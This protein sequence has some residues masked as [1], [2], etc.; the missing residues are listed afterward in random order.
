MADNNSEKFSNVEN[1]RVPH[2]LRVE[3]TS[4]DDAMVVRQIGATILGLRLNGIDVLT[5]GTDLTP[6]EPDERIKIDATHTMLPAGPN[7]QGPIQGPQHGPSRYLEYGVDQ[8]DEASAFFRAHV[9]M[10]DLDHSTAFRVG[11][12]TAEI[13]DTAANVTDAET[14]LSIGKHLYLKVAE[15]DLPN[16]RFVET[17]G[18]DTRLAGHKQSGKAGEPF[19]GDFT[20]IVDHISQ[21]KTVFHERFTGSQLIEI[22]GIGRL[23]LSANALGPDGQAVPVM[24][25]LWHR[26]GSDT[27]CFE[28]VAGFRVDESGFYNTEIPVSPGGSIQLKT[29]L[30]LVA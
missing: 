30:E 2:G 12:G 8:P 23:R 28:P 14:G 9:P 17:D 22:T 19:E 24:L 13:V 6:D 10:W 5:T 27:V 7:D 4:G 25:W 21:G 29:K 1:E 15:E 26:P 3:L 11:G 18:S 16:I 20:D